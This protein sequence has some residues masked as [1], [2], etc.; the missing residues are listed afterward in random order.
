M[1]SIM[2]RLAKKWSLDMYIMICVY[3]YIYIYIYIYT[4]HLS[5]IMYLSTTDDRRVRIVSGIFV[6]L[7]LLSSSIPSLSAMSI[8]YRSMLCD[9]QL[10]S[11]VV[12]ALQSIVGVLTSEGMMI[13]L[14]FWY[15]DDGWWYCIVWETPIRPWIHIPL[16]TPC[17]QADKLCTRV[18]I[19][20]YESE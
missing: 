12:M 11:T 13:L 9:L 4:V 2:Q 3:I 1:I 16:Y 19:Q 20:Y 14:L 6:S 10:T 8:Y 15:V 5:H 18:T 7:W 17:T